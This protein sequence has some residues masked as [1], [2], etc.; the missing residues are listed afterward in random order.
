MVK[1]ARQYNITSNPLGVK[2]AVI[3]SG[4]TWNTNQEEIEH[5]LQDRLQALHAFAGSNCVMIGCS[6]L[7]Q[8]LERSRNAQHYPSD[9]DNKSSKLFPFTIQRCLL[10]WGFHDHETMVK[11][12]AFAHQ[13]YVKMYGTCV[14]GNQNRGS[15]QSASSHISP[16]DPGSVYAVV[17][18]PHVTVANF[19]SDRKLCNQ[20]IDAFKRQQN[21]SIIFNGY[22]HFHRHYTFGLQQMFTQGAVSK[23]YDKVW[24]GRNY[25]KLHEKYKEQQRMLARDGAVVRSIPSAYD[26]LDEAS[27]EF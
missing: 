16:D 3:P 17:C 8:W 11:A 10:A 5:M 20:R 21:K 22:D 7:R 14:I 6:Y 24:D 25:G 27:Q 15:I 18:A 13:I 23:S 12:E 19:A 4:W 2:P 1:A 9:A 26:Q